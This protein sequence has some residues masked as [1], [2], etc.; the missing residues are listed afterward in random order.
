MLTACAELDSHDKGFRYTKSENDY[1]A[2][3]RWGEWNTVLYLIRPKPEKVIM[4][5]DSTNEKSQQVIDVPKGENQ[6]SREELVD[7]LSTVKVKRLEVLSSSMGSDGISGQ[8][9]FKI[10]YRFDNSTKLNELRYKVTWWYDK[11]TNTW[12][13][14]TPLPPEFMPP[15]AEPSKRKTIKL[16]PDR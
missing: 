15:K 16:S 7:H 1:R 3:M 6:Y 14:D 9:R 13:S 8:S 12:F 10:Q 4:K 11:D 5:V 2:G